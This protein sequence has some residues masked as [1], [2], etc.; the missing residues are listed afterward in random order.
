MGLKRNKELKPDR[1]LNIAQSRKTIE[2]E[3]AIDE[4][5]VNALR[6]Y[7]LTAYEARA[8]YVLLTVGE[9]SA[10]TVAKLSGIPQQ[11]IYDTLTSLERKG[12][13][14]VMHTNPK[15]YAALN[16]RRALSNRIRQ[17]RAEFDARMEELKERIDEIERH[18][19]RPQSSSGGSHVWIIEGEEAIIGRILEMIQSAEKSV[20]L[21]GERPLFT[22][23]CKGILKKHLSR[24]VKLYALGTFE[25]VCRDEI[26]DL[27][28]EVRDMES[29][30]HYLLIVHDSRLLMVY[31][32]DEGIPYGLY[33]E[34]EDVIRPHVY[35]F[36]LLWNEGK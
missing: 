30:S 25:R 9:A 4:A 36:D 31:F 20:K 13:I 18:V 34:N 5:F 21:A 24:G 17:L 8:Y 16:V 26:L 23:N 32:D 2:M 22:L 29:Y 6:D 11:R 19:P 10:G 3:V 27:G 14:Q 28:G 33:T 15:K 7:G 12:F 35:L 1:R